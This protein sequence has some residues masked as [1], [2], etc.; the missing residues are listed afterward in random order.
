[1]A[2]LNNLYPP[3]VNTYAPAFLIDSI[4]TS[5]NTCKIYFS[6]SLYNSYSDIQNAQVTICNQNTN[7]SVLNEEKYP[8]GI[9]LTN[10]YIDRER[11]SD[12]KYYIEIKKTDMMN[13]Q[14]EINQY[15]KVQIRFTSVNASSISMTTPQ[16]IDS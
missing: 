9:M 8:C 10:I 1:M 11:E 13:N 5:K 6:I 12:D 3:I 4:N 2:I 7:T 14:F 15:Y 16:A